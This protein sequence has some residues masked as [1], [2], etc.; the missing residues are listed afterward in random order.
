MAKREEPA[1]ARAEELLERLGSFDEI[2]RYYEAREMAIHDEVT[3]LTG[4]KAEGIAEGIAKGRTEGRTEGRAEGRIEGRIEGIAEGR[5]EG[6]AEGRVEGISE[7]ERK[8]A[9]QIA[10]SLL[11][12]L[13]DKVISEKT[14]LPIEEVAKLRN[15]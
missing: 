10:R 15:Q 1:I 11:D 13:D 3:R 12:V 7:G 14:G 9:L 6:I 5:I 4:A 2:R 8:K